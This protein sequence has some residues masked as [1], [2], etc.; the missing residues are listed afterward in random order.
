MESEVY[1]TDKTED[2]ESQ[3]P[4]AAEGGCS[5]CLAEHLNGGIIVFLMSMGPY[6]LVQKPTDLIVFGC[7]QTK[8]LILLLRFKWKYKFF[9][10]LAEVEKFA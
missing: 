2:R 3:Q 6:I 1:K 10:C 4:L 5:K 9:L 8:T 7:I